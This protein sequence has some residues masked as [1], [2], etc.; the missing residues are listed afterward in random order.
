MTLA[1]SCGH[2]P[3]LLDGDT[4]QSTQLVWDLRHL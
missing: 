2:V 3:L 4:D 1:S